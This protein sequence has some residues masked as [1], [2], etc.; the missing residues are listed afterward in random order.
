MSTF[1]SDQHYLRNSV[2]AQ[3]HR[4]PAP[5]LPPPSFFKVIVIAAT[6]KI[7][8]RLSFKYFSCFSKLKL[9]SQISLQS[10]LNSFP[11]DLIEMRYISCNFIEFYQFSAR[12]N[13]QSP[14]EIWVVCECECCPASWWTFVEYLRLVTNLAA[15]QYRS[16]YL[17]CVTG[18]IQASQVTGNFKEYKIRSSTLQIWILSNEH[19]FAFYRILLSR[20]SMQLDFKNL[21]DLST[22]TLFLVWC[23]N[24]ISCYWT[25]WHDARPTVYTF[26]VIKS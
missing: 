15:S 3:L 1:R 10:W 18:H 8:S 2:I 11:S 25:P 13:E 22:E 16:D 5:S 24:L 17:K 14:A 26:R 9:T 7:F 12:Q 4:A 19:T 20:I 23:V 21:I 6:N